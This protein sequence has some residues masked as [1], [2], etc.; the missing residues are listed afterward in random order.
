MISAPPI[1]RTQAAEL[2]KRLV[3]NFASLR[4]DDK[5]QFQASV[6]EV[7]EHYPLGLVQECCDPHSGLASKI[8]FLSIKSIVEWCD[9]RLE[10]HQKLAQVTPRKGTPKPEFPDNP[11]MAARVG[12]LLKGLVNTLRENQRAAYSAKVQEVMGPRPPWDGTITQALA[13]AESARPAGG[14]AVAE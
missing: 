3:G 6:N 9:K 5:V 2:G 13:A 7:L 10:L 4:A 1:T 12:L 8:E 11:T 14:E